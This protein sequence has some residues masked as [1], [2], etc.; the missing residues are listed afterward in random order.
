MLAGLTGLL[1]GGGGAAGSFESI[2]TVTAAGG[3]TT[4]TFNS[5]SSAYKHLQIRGLYKDTFSAS[6][7][8]ATLHL[9]F[10][11][12]SAT[13]YTTHVLNG[14]GTTASSSAQTGIT[15][16]NI[17]DAGITAGTGH[18]NIFG[19]S[20]IEIL[21]YAST[22]KNKTTRS[23]SGNNVN[24]TSTSFGVDLNSGLWLST[25]A[26]TRIDLIRD[27]TA[28]FAGST[29]ALYGIKG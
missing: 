8:N 21:D 13:N 27:S 22:T 5:I 2:A 14:N 26:V 6:L 24:S 4:L 16:I 28:F 7:S 3:E 10:N 23:I 15:Y 20:M 29:F 12:D 25:A 1:G 11:N 9:R 17:P 18:T 19:S